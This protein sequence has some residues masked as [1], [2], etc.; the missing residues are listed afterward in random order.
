MQSRNDVGDLVN[1]EILPGVEETRIPHVPHNP[2]ETRDQR[3]RAQIANLSAAIER[4]AEKGGVSHV[5]APLPA[6]GETVEIHGLT[7]KVKYSSP[8]RGKL[9]LE[10]EEPAEHL[11]FVRA[12][13]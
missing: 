10:I 4:A 7:Y 11:H 9:V 2:K 12:Q 13:V 1:T 6:C 5:V 8:G 3:L